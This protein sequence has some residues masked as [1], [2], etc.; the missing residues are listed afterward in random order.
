MKKWKVVF[1]VFAVF[2]VM[3][4]ISLP[5]QNDLDSSD[6]ISLIFGGFS[7]IPL[8]GFANQI[9][10][11]N[12]PI[13]IILFLINLATMGLVSLIG[14][15]DTI[16]NFSALQLLLTAIVSSL[17]AIFLYPQFMYAF[18]SKHLWDTNA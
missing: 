5:F 4:I 16:E 10:I 9:T 8:Y 3:G 13:A 12:K 18:K 2:Y 17:A 1:W 11:G 7:L 15:I 14:I 6:F